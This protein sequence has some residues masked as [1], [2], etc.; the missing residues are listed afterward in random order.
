MP[1]IG[2]SKVSNTDQAL[3]GKAVRLCSEHAFW[4]TSRNETSMTFAISIRI[5]IFR[6][7]AAFGIAQPRNDHALD[8]A[9]LPQIRKAVEPFFTLGRAD[10]GGT[11]CSNTCLFPHHKAPVEQGYDI[12]HPQNRIKLK[13]V[14][15]RRGS[16]AAFE[17]AL[18]LVGD[19]HQPLHSADSHDK[20]GC[21]R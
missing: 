2:R 13:D 21:P 15:F 16:D 10:P 3:T 17:L 7:S 4:G 14:A 5:G 19:I 18:H 12:Y 6:S 8:N 11:T 20:G 1:I 9:L